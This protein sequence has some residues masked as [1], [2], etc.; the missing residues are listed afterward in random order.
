M[1]KIPCSRKWQPTPKFLPRKTHRQRNLWAIVHGVAKSQRWLSACTHTHTHTHTHMHTFVST[2]KFCS[3]WK[4]LRYIKRF[5]KEISQGHFRHNIYK[6]QPKA[7]A[8]FTPCKFMRYIMGYCF[9]T[10]FNLLFFFSIAKQIFLQI[11]PN[12][13]QLKRMCVCCHFYLTK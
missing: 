7:F 13:T 2:W 10:C 3:R 6:L 5:K 11:C 9:R 1:G 4:Q 12:I 8:D